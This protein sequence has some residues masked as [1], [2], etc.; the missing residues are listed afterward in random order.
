MDDL[1]GRKVD[2]FWP[3]EEAWFGGTVTAKGKKPTADTEDGELGVGFQVEYDDG[4]EGWVSHLRGNPLVRFVGTLATRDGAR[5]VSPLG[6]PIGGTDGDVIGVAV[7]FDEG[8]VAFA[9]NGVWHELRVGQPSL[10]EG[11]YPAISGS[12]CIVLLNLGARPFR[13]PRDGFEAACP[14][15][16]LGA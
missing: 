10:R 4:D 3:E 6:S 7:D 14:S 12:S 9:Q 8:V 11:V 15:A 5:V 2:V 13:H 1:I 16:A